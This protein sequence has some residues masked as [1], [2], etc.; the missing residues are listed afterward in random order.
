MGFDMQDNMSAYEGIAASYQSLPLIALRELH[1]ILS[2][3]IEE[4]VKLFVH[5][6]GGENVRNVEGGL[7]EGI[8]T[9]VDLNREKTA[10]KSGFVPNLKLVRNG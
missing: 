10:G 8:V 1:S 9:E 5:E 3:E 6:N 4:R 7:G 2:I